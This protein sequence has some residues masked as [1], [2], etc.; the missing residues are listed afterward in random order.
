MNNLMILQYRL[1]TVLLLF[2]ASFISAQS[3]YKESFNVGDGVLVSVNTSHTNVVFETWNKNIVEV[4][5]FVDDESLSAKEKKEIF[6]HWDLEVLGNSRKV[7]ITSNE[8]SLWTGIE[9]L[10]SLKAL[11]RMDIEALKGLEGLE[12][13]KGLGDMDWNFEVPNI[14]DFKDFPKW[15]FTDGRAS[16]YSEDENT[17]YNFN[18]EFNFKDNY[19]FDRSK[20]NKDKKAYVKKLN[21][22]YGADV[23]VRETDAWLEDVDMWAEDFEQVMEDWGEDF[24]SKFEHQFGPEFEKKMEIWGEEFG[25][26]MEKWGEEF[27]E[28]F[29]EEMEKWGEEFGKSMEKWGEEFGKDVEKWAEEYDENGDRAIFV[30]SGK[31]GLLY[32]K[33]VKAKKTII[34]RL[35]KGS[36]TDINVRYGEVKMA[37]A[38]NVKATLNY[39]KLTA[40]SID[41]GETLINAAYAPVYVNNWGNGMLDLKYV[42]DCKLNEVDRIHLQANS[43]NVNINSLGKEAFLTGSF[44]NLYVNKIRNDFETI[45]IVLENTD[46]TL[47]MP[48]IAFTFYYNGNKSRFKKPTGLILTSEKTTDSRSLLKGYSKAKG[49]DR[50][51]TIK[52]SYSNVNFKN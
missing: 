11:H 15:P 4:E 45:D 6:D 17:D 3:S 5:A 2:F 20:Y 18:F 21:K 13:L 50:S 34:I 52:A 7:V 43:S 32:K 41:G 31:Q 28:K 19:T 16:I 10:G 12:A 8:G 30:P 35:P 22:K 33:A 23:T 25:E 9:S 1:S 48:D 38:W 36:K 39:A 27:G 14:P 42:E 26:S 47:S 51:M 29:G 24:G 49:S 44:G 37:D 46:A 40:N